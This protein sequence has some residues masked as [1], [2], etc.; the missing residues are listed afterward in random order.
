MSWKLVSSKVEFVLLLHLEKLSHHSFGHLGVGKLFL[1][2]IFGKQLLRCECCKNIALR[3][4]CTRLLK[5]LADD[6]CLLRSILT[7]LQCC[8][9]NEFAIL[10]F[11]GTSREDRS[12]I[13]FLIWLV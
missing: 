8:L 7:N 1:M 6:L 4:L 9:L 10:I 3:G 11:M 2:V 13:N 5:Y 12:S